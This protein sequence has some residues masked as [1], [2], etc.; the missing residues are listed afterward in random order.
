MN[1]YSFKLTLVLLNTLYGIFMLPP[2]P[3]KDGDILALKWIQL[4]SKVRKQA[5]IRN[6]YNQEPHLT[7]NT[8][9]ESDKNTIKHHKRQPRDNLQQNIE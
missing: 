8:T 1:I 5:K 6:R 2:P 9:L 3:T 7:L 4:A